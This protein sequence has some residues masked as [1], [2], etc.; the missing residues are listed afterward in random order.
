MAG[1]DDHKIR[2]ESEVEW[3]P[4]SGATDTS[5]GDATIDNVNNILNMHKTIG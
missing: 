1:M 5:T 2:T 4:A 3:I